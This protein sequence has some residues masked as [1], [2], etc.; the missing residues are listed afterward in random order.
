MSLRRYAVEHMEKIFQEVYSAVL[1]HSRATF[2]TENENKK[3]KSP[4]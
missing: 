2:G 3:G 4:N 1:L